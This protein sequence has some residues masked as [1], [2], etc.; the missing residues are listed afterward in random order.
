MVRILPIISY[1]DDISESIANP[2]LER[3][4]ARAVGN[5]G[6]KICDRRSANPAA[7]GYGGFLGSTIDTICEPYWSASGFSPPGM[8]SPFTG[9]QCDG[10]IYDI[11]AEQWNAVQQVW[12][13]RAKVG[14]GTNQIRGPVTLCRVVS[15]GA[16][17]GGLGPGQICNFEVASSFSGG[18]TLNFTQGCNTNAPG[19]AIAFRNVGPVLASGGVD[20]CGDPPG[21]VAPGPSPAPDPG[22]PS[23]GEDAYDDPVSGPVLP[24]PDLPDNPGSPGLPLPRFPFGSPSGPAF[25]PG[26][27]GSPGAPIETGLGSESGAG[28]E[29]E[30][31]APEGSEIVG[32]RLDLVAA[33]PKPREYG[34]G[35][36][37]GAA[38]IRVGTESGLDQDLGG[39]RILTGQ[40]FF[41]E[42]SGLTKWL[43]TATIGYNWLVTPYYR[44]VV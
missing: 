4:F 11:H 10:Q 17:A 34:D 3:P 39:V 41:A 22:P 16:C 12:N 21:E 33:P 30:G 40:F 35:I 23:P 18:Q 14:G 9:G 26:D 42:T 2:P 37:I 15:G 29:A 5:A 6:R 1:L 7:Q 32:L 38:Y 31:E 19:G 20:N 43:V 28:G 13:P 8:V 25:P 36:Y 44:E 24:V 27:T